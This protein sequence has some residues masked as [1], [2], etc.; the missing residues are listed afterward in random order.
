MPARFN[1]IAFCFAVHITDYYIEHSA[2]FFTVT[3]LLW[4]TDL[5]S[6]L[7]LSF[8]LL[9]G[10][11]SHQAWK[12]TTLHIS[13][14]ADFYRVNASNWLVHILGAFYVRSQADCHSNPY[15]I[16]NWIGV[17]MRGRE[18]KQPLPA[19]FFLSAEQL[20]LVVFWENKIK[21]CS[22][23]KVDQNENEFIKSG[24]SQNKA[25]WDLR[26]LKHPQFVWHEFE[27]LS[28]KFESTVGLDEDGEACASSADCSEYA[29]GGPHLR[30]I[31]TL[32]FTLTMNMCSLMASL[33]VCLQEG[34]ASFPICFHGKIWQTVEF[35][36]G[37][38]C[39]HNA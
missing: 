16:Y 20:K 22:L 19:L 27:T 31:L 18:P 14:Q 38:S 23:F 6:S 24:N 34:Y 28:K 3:I 10:Q 33:R 37:W 30:N 13:R 32:W 36:S 7:T 21:P 9:A 2:T 12:M 39:A 8:A 35:V 4:E 15:S 26:F 17:A 1:Y 29:S 11:L 5:F 25:P